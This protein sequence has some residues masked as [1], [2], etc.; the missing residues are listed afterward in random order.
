MG[1]LEVNSHPAQGS[2]TMAKVDKALFAR[3]FGDMLGAFILPALDGAAP[4]LGGFGELEL[5]LPSQ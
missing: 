3:L 4:R 2:G 1:L 5:D